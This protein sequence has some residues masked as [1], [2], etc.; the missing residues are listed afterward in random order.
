MSLSAIA[1]FIYT[2]IPYAAILCII[3][4]RHDLS[5]LVHPLKDRCSIRDWKSVFDDL[6]I[7][8]KASSSSSKTEGN[9]TVGFSI[10]RLLLDILERHPD[11]GFYASMLAIVTCV[12]L[13]SS[14][15]AVPVLI[16]GDSFTYSRFILIISAGLQF[17]SAIPSTF[18]MQRY[19]GPFPSPPG[20]FHLKKRR[21]GSL[22]RYEKTLNQQQVKCFPGT[23]LRS[24]RLW[25]C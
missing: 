4:Y 20:K 1:F 14:L 5:Q 10:E 7:A 16:G 13:L 19:F 8:H 12:S 11:M 17:V 6:E 23:I 24:E 22:L 15:L 25:R 2:P 18:T 21:P 3:L 9:G